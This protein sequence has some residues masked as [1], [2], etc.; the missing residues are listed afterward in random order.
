MTTVYY[1]SHPQVTID[2]H[3]PVS[4][5]SLSAEGHTRCLAV[6]AAPWIVGIKT[7]VGSAETKAV[8]TLDTVLGPD[9]RAERV[10]RAAMHENDRSATG[11]V[12]PDRFEVLADRFFAHPDQSVEGWETA[13][14]A[15]A[16]IVRETQ[17]VLGQATTGPV[18]LVGH[19]GVGTL[20]LCHLQ[21]A[22]IARDR[23]QP[24]GGGNVFAFDRDSW[25]VHHG[26]VAMEDVTET[27]QESTPNQ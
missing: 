15:Q 25:A 6:R 24:P 19:G 1:L 4:Q 5:W 10:V 16:R 7:A 3:T 2:P 8:E 27:R 13:R 14:D 26:W 22:P 23:D 21:G 12:P 17:A 20:L 18:L 11:F 9:H